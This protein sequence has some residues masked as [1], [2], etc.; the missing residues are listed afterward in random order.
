MSDTGMLYAAF[1]KSLV[2]VASFAFGLAAFGCSKKTPDAT[3]SAAPP[4]LTSAEAKAHERAAIAAAAAG[5]DI[6][7]TDPPS[8]KR[9]ERVVPMRK[10]TYVIPHAPDDKEDGEL[11]IF[12]FGPTMGGGV[13]ANV[14]RWVK[15]FSDVPVDKVKRA[16]RTAN[17]LVEHTVE[18]ES[19]TFNANSMMQGPAKPK[20]NFALLGAIVEAPSGSYFFKLTGPAATVAAARADFYKL[21][22]GVHSK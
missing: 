16:D 9:S 19:G 20:P 3:K 6:V 18:I 10:A 8:W 12:Y 4:P 15:Q 13:D 2:F 1:M 14:D 17:G 21:L 5:G 7:W 22:D 11:G